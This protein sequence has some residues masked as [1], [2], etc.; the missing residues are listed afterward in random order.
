[1]KKPK[2][3]N[4]IE[5]AKACNGNLGAIAA[6]FEVT[7]RTIHNWMNED[8]EFRDAVDDHKGALLDR[9][10][11]TATV[12]ALGIVAR[13]E[14]G[15]VVGWIEK[16]DPSMLRYFMSTLGR[17]EGFGEN[18][19]ITSNGEKIESPARVLTKKEIKDLYKNLNEDY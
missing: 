1:M 11:S 13:D 4:F 19:D 10:I 6:S 16:P 12:V 17:K 5:V 2:I 3:K 14:N 8:P 15:K 7:R 9:C 18:V